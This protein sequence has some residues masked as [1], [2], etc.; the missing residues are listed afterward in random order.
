MSANDVVSRAEAGLN[1]LVPALAGAIGMSRGGLY[2]AIARGEVASVRIG[3]AIFV[4]AHE[5]RRLLG[6][7]SSKSLAA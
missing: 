6:M 4:P 7:P 2:Q 1:V 5:A 3:R